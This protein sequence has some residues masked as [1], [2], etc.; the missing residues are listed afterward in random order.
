MVD[1]YLLLGGNLGNK[2]AI[3]TEAIVRL[4]NMIGILHKKSAIYETE[5]WG[6]YCNEMFWNQALLIKTKLNPKEVLKYT[7]LIEVELGRVREDERYSSRTIDIDLL[8][9]GNLVINE[10]NLELPHP[11]IINRR[12]VLEPL[13]DLDPS[14]VHPAFN[15]TIE[16]LLQEC[17]DTLS[18]TKLK[19]ELKLL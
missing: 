2:A 11:R 12:F 17:T 16:N 4:S 10:K 14:F 1:L 7:K 13:L 15:K 8:F 5:P 19:D 3:F 9:Y 18:C 6:F